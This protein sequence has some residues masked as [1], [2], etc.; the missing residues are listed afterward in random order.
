MPWLLCTVIAQAS[1]SGTWVM[2]ARSLPFSSIFHFDGSARMRLPPR[3]RTIGIAVLG[4]E[5]VDHAERAV[6]VAAGGIVLGEHHH[7][8]LL[9]LELSP[10]TGS[11]A[12]ARARKAPVPW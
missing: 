1:L 11:R 10:A 3:V 8:A 6:D 12:A 4:I 7:R 5:I 2:L 9:E